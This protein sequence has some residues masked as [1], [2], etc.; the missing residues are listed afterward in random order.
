MVSK[1]IANFILPMAIP[2]MNNY[3]SREIL[4]CPFVIAGNFLMRVNLCFDTA[5]FTQSRE[6]TIILIDGVKR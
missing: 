1:L 6:I 5:M 2:L 3:C 4:Y